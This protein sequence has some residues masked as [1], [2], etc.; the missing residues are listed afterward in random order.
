MTAIDLSLVLPCYDEA[1]H[2]RRSVAEI[3]D[4]LEQT[5]W[6]WEIVFVDDVSRDDTR[7][8]IG[9]LCAA[10]PRLRAVFHERNRGRGAAFKTGF[11]AASGRT[12]G[13]ID[14]DL[15][16]H[17]R[18]IPALVALVDE[19]DVDVAT[20]RRYYNLRQTGAL[21]RALLSW[22]YRRLCAVLL[23][24]GVRDSETGCKFFNRATASDVVLGSESDGWFW[25]TEVMVRAAL[26]GLV[27]H[28]MPVLFLRRRDKQS[29]VRVLSDSIAYLRALVRFRRSTGFTFA[30]T[31]P[32]YWSGIGYDLV[33]RALYGRQYASL[34]GDVAWRIPAGASVVDVCCGTAR[35]YRDHLRGQVG[36]YLGLD[37]NPHLVMAARRKGVPVRHF[38]VRT[39]PIPVADYVVMCSSL[40][41]FGA[42]ADALLAR[43][44][45]AARKGVIVSEPVRNLSQM[46]IIGR[47]S[48]RLTNPGV[49]D[50]AGRYD[51]ETFRRFAYANDVVEVWRPKGA[52]NAIA[53]FPPGPGVADRKTRPVGD[54]ATAPVERGP[55]RTRLRTAL[56]LLGGG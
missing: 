47:L 56:A 5:R 13:F 39:D 20:G 52:R 18:Y 30:G 27:V 32:I 49:G 44:R 10:D 50:F 14:V 24:V 34:Y 12:T 42:T 26:A 16:V 22:V 15:E 53:V 23:N 11:R 29:T 7:A 28:E 46:P 25:D 37:V 45:A 36:S 2:L 3:V 35:L 21:H 51:L 48:A 19:R 43:M 1:A 55:V 9:E 33:M 40:Y 17:A 41:H 31:A 54:T 4:V 38:D 6:S 8:V